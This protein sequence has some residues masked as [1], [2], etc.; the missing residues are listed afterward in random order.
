MFAKMLASNLHSEVTDMDYFT[1]SLLILIKIL[2]K[3][4]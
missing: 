3:I 1:S 2:I 4:L